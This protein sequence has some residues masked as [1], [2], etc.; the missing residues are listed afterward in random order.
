MED[1]TGDSRKGKLV[2]EKTFKIF[3][4]RMVKGDWPIGHN[5]IAQMGYH[6]AVRNMHG[7]VSVVLPDGT[8][9][10]VKPGEFEEVE[11]LEPIRTIAERTFPAEVQ[12]I[13][14]HIDSDRLRGK[15]DWDKECQE[16]RRLNR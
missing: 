8:R 2:S 4:P 10:G 9:L 15:T 5:I 12:E 6:N 11:D 13:R 1:R 3:L 14:Q 7:A 16:S